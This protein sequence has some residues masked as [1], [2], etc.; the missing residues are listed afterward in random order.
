LRVAQRFL[1]LRGDDL[2]GGI[3][4][5]SFEL[6]E[7]GEVRSWWVDSRCVAV[8]AH[9]DT[10]DVTPA[11]D[12]PIDDLTPVVRQLGSPFV[13]VDLAKAD[14]GKWRVIEVGDGQVSDRP[15]GLAPQVLLRAI[16]ENETDI[17]RSSTDE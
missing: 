17:L 9:P 13:T 16:N 10:P 14:L 1:E 5:R 2:V 15:P 7:P 4:V 11:G 8:S 12:V 6:Y 3:V